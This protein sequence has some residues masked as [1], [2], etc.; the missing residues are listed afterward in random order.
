MDF[1]DYENIEIFNNTQR[2]NINKCENQLIS[3]CD[4]DNWKKI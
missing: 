1:S 2:F 4:Y 3:I